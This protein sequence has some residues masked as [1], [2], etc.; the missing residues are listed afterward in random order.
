[1]KLCTL[2]LNLLFKYFFHRPYAFV[3]WSVT[4]YCPISLCLHTHKRCNVKKTNICSPF[5][6]FCGVRN[7]LLL[8][9]ILFQPGRWSHVIFGT[10]DS[11]NCGFTELWIFVELSNRDV[12]PEVGSA[13]PS[14]WA[15]N[16][17]RGW[18][19]YRS[20]FTLLVFFHVIKQDSNWIL[21]YYPQFYA[22]FMLHRAWMHLSFCLQIN[23]KKVSVLAVKYLLVILHRLPTDRVSQLAIPVVQYTGTWS[24]IADHSVEPVRRYLQS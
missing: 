5:R 23:L 7:F 13:L 8:I 17:M 2:N 15:D 1:M 22:M 19:I 9:H 24:N 11:R 12:L 3:S 14:G 21:N 10:V 4:N 6:S 18:Y 16:Y 20:V